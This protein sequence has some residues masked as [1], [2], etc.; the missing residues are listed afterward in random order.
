MIL[1]GALW[2][3]GLIALITLVWWMRSLWSMVTVWSLKRTV[4]RRESSLRNIEAT[5]LDRE[6]DKRFLERLI[7][8]LSR[9][10]E[11]RQ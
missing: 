3:V 1:T 9:G 7:V 6:K 10:T 8:E 2:F 4:E 5:I 11:S